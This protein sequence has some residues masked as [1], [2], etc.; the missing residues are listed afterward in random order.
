[1]PGEYNCNVPE[2]HHRAVEDV[3][4]YEGAN[5][6]EKRYLAAKPRSINLNCDILQRRRFQQQLQY[7]NGRRSYA[8]SAFE[9]KLFSSSSST[10]K[11]SHQSI[12]TRIDIHNMAQGEG[13]TTACRKACD[14]GEEKHGS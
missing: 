9:P 4:L 13:S 6:N 5:E 3:L 1:M 2:I 11:S 12:R 10:S 7:H 14:A 8:L